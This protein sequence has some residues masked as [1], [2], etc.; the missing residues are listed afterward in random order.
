M[1]YKQIE[2]EVARFSLWIGLFAFIVCTG[3][4]FVEGIFTG[5]LLFTFGSILAL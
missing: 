2:K 4:W 5:L 1:K 3:I